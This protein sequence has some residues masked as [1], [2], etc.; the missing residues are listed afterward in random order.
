MK[1]YIT[2][3][4]CIILSF[5]FMVLSISLYAQSTI[6]KA[7]LAMANYEYAKAITIYTDYFNTVSPG[8]N[9][10]RD[11]SNCYVMIGETKKAEEWMAK[12]IAKEDYAAADVFTYAKILKSNGKYAEAS[13]RFNEYS[14]LEPSEASKTKKWITSCQNAIA[15]MSEDSISFKVQNVSAINSENADFGL[16][17]LGKEYIFSSDRTHKEGLF[18]N[19]I[20]EWTGAPYLKIYSVN[21]NLNENSPKIS[22]VDSLNFKFHNGQAAYDSIHQIIYFTRTKRIS[23]KQSPINIDPTHWR[24]TSDFSGYENRLEIYT[25]KYAN[26]KWSDVK[27]FPFNNPAY[28]VGH[29]ALSPD[30]K[31][32]YFVSDMPEGFGD[33][34]IY[35]CEANKD[36]S[37]KAPV[38]AGKVVNSEYKEVFPYIDKKGTLYFSS[39]NPIGMGGLDVYITAGSKGN[40]TKPRNIGFPVN[41]SKDDFSVFIKETDKC[42]YFSS[43]RDGG[44]GSDDIYSFWPLPN[45]QRIIVVKAY[46][47]LSD[48]SLKEIHDMK[49]VI[50]NEMSNKTYLK[51]LKENE[52]GE[53]T[54]IAEL[55]TPY[56][57]TMIKKGYNVQTKTI[58]VKKTDGDT[59]F[60]D[61]VT[62]RAEILSVVGKV[63]EKG[64]AVS[65]PI[66]EAKLVV[67]NPE[68]D[69]ID[70]LYSDKNGNF[71][72]KIDIGKPYSCT[73][74]KEGYY[75]ISK[76]L[77]S[78]L[79]SNNDSVKLEI[80]TYMMK[81]GFISESKSSQTFSRND[82]VEC[83]MLM[84]KI[85]L[86]E[87]FVINNIYY[88][89]KKWDIRPDAAIE[90]DK[91]V[92]ML[93]KNPSVRIE[94]SSHTDSR[95]SDGYNINLSQK[96][97]N[98]AVSYIISK[99]I[100]ANRIIA[101]GY[102]ERKLMNKCISNVQCSEEEHQLNRRTEIKIIG[103]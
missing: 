55:T 16:I 96:R 44:K 67:E 89:Y 23:V 53:Y 54:D 2:N 26:G 92:E 85:Q 81:D 48:N 32:L 83:I 13:T 70:S 72:L 59:V 45:V 63:K 5:S 101:K 79:V 73:T 47:L 21:G 1:T 78:S 17:S 90:L 30:C 80:T 51:T 75:T 14:K 34:D 100:K 3:F 24:N 49:V 8:V 99:G 57:I 41:S 102:G 6:E 61:I 58:K 22:L 87:T 4:K 93:K 37:W 11:L 84:D 38:N 65:P 74:T 95:G 97:A 35:Y 43:N 66:K 28:S 60:V 77:T 39:D 46:E 12:V 62:K 76:T 103:K 20:C 29:P 64:A 50:K 25:A 27:P 82:T 40:W 98:A 36:G 42:G 91:V 33:N 10:M 7:K 18:D 69:Y 94:L 56:E 71:K 19:D 52:K 9:E 31:V 15:W 86:N 68:E 88:D